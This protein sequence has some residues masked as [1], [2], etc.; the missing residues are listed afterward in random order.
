MRKLFI[1]TAAVCSLMSSLASAKTEGNYVGIDLVQT[2]T[3]ATKTKDGNGTTP[4]ST[5]FKVRDENN[6]SL[7]LNYKYAFNFNNFF[8]APGVL[9]DYANVSAHDSVND[10]WNLDYRLGLNIDLG[11]DITDK[12]AVFA[13]T[14]LVNNYYHVNW[15]GNKEKSGSD[16]SLSYGLGAKYSVLDNLDAV[17]SYETSS[18]DMESPNYVTKVGKETTR[19]ELDIIKIGASYKF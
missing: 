12:I 2:Q 17:L 4:N 13:K 11:Y 3:S 10:S 1:T 7:G 14:G 18:L 19:F 15:A 16:L 5:T 8:I 9:V 6:I